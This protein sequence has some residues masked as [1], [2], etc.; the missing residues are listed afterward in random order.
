VAIRELERGCRSAEGRDRERWS[1][2][3]SVVWG[4]AIHRIP[5]GEECQGCA[6]QGELLTWDDIRET[7][8]QQ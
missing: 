2:R 4:C 6:D 8:R 3:R 1:T 5:A 7:Q